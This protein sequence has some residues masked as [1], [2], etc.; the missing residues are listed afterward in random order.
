M[1]EPAK[2][3]RSKK[4]TKVRTPGGKTVT[5]FKRPRANRARSA[6]SGTQLSGVAT[7]TATQL[8]NMNKSSKVPSRPYAG[9]LAPQELDNLIRYLARTEAKYGSEQMRDLNLTRNLV[10]EKYLP[11]GWFEKASNGE[12]LVKTEKS[13]P[14]R[15]AKPSKDAAETKKKPKIK[16][17]KE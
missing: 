7:G 16:K 15:H 1:V 6:I 17:K 14:K 9:V 10:L 11:R 4:K 5:H 13:K 8:K 3:T 2:R 12:I